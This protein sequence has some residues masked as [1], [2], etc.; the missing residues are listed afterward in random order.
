MCC[1]L[2]MTITQDK[3]LVI[4][5][6]Q[7]KTKYYSQHTANHTAVVTSMSVYVSGSQLIQLAVLLIIYDSKNYMQRQSD[8]LTAGFLPFFSNVLRRRQPSHSYLAVYKSGEKTCSTELSRLQHTYKLHSVIH[9]PTTVHSLGSWLTIYPVTTSQA[10]S[11]V[12]ASTP[13]VTRRTHH[14]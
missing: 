3:S 8:T 11:I 10:R 6:Q 9:S 13:G 4:T 1:E 12:Y 14:Q 7:T 2:S 5:S